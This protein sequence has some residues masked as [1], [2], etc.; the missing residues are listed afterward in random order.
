MNEGD[1]HTRR[2]ATVGSK[3][4][5]W[6]A[7]VCPY[8][9]SKAKGRLCL[10]RGSTRLG[11]G[12]RSSKAAKRQSSPQHVDLCGSWS[13]VGSSTQHVDLCGIWSMG[14]WLGQVCPGV[15]QGWN[16]VSTHQRQQSGRLHHNMW[17]SVER[18][19]RWKSCLEFGQL[20]GRVGQ[21]WSSWWQCFWMFFEFMAGWNQG[22][23][24]LG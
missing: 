13:M 17:I 7:S 1:P 19:N 14:W 24:L 15:Q 20:V 2:I 23:I 3:C 4:E 9:L 10:S 5:I 6:L 11:L 16:L 21:G 22:L 18:A 12:L 8:C